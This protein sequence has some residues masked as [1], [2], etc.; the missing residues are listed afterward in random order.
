M[1]KKRS[2]RKG[3]GLEEGVFPGLCI[4]CISYARDE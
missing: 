3:G 4:V 2:E 1:I